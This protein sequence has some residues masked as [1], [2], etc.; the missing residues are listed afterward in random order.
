MNTYHSNFGPKNDTS[1]PLFSNTDTLNENTREASDNFDFEDNFQPQKT[2]Q[3]IM[4]EK[5]ELLYK[6]EAL[7]KKGVKLPREFTIESDLA[8]CCNNTRRC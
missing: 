4:N 1:Q 8:S 5:Y 2:Q 6:F 7:K 3:E